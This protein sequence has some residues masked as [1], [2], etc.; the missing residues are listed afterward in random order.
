MASMLKIIRKL[1]GIFLLVV[2]VV[3]SLTSFLGVYSVVYFAASEN[4]V[5]TSMQVDPTGLL[6]EPLSRYLYLGNITIN[7]TG[8]YSID[9]LTIEFELGENSSNSTIV[10]YEK[11][12]GSIKSAEIKNIV[13]NLTQPDAQF[14]HTY[15]DEA[16]NG[17]GVIIDQN[18]IKGYLTISGTYAIL[19]GFS[20]NITDLS[21][22]AFA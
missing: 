18:N 2:N 9:D 3:L 17:S 5:V 6:N 7:N 10:H 12:F 14:N 22:W 15:I 16:I 8:L 19:F 1:A 4:N 20:L 11:N 13:V 21:S